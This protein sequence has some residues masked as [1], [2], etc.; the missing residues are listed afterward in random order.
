MVAHDREH[1]YV[2]VEWYYKAGAPCLSSLAYRVSG[3]IKLHDRN[4]RKHDENRVRGENRV[5][6]LLQRERGTGGAT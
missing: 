4:K 5:T 6:K 1:A 2:G 3:S